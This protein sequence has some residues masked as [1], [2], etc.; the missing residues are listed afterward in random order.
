MNEKSGHIDSHQLV[1]VIV[2]S[3]S[4]KEQKSY[5]CKISLAGV[6]RDHRGVMG[7]QN[8]P[9]EREG[10]RQRGCR[11]QICRWELHLSRQT[12]EGGVPS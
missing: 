9:E 6:Q 1:E 11:S 12:E 3:P 10:L 5:L 8:L 7:G 4:F 2:F